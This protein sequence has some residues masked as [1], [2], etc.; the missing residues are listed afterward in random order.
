MLHWTEQP[1]QHGY[2]YHQ[3]GVCPLSADSLVI[4]VFIMPSIVKVR[5][6]AITI[7]RY[8]HDKPMRNEQWQLRGVDDLSPVGQE[9]P[10]LLARVGVWPENVA[11]VS[12][13]IEEFLIRESATLKEMLASIG[14]TH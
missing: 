7:G 6:I 4:D 2:I 3:R 1:K 13:E 10:A 8:R 5:P 9:L 12:H 11:S 14:Q